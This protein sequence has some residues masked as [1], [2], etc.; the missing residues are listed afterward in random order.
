MVKKSGGAKTFRV[1]WMALVLIFL[2]APIL[3][4][5]GLSFNA[6]VSPPSGRASR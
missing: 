5:I 2:Y 6:S 4:M 1:L 3:V